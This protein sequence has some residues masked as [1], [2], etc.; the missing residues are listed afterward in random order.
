MIDWGLLQ[1]TNALGSYVS[2]FEAGRQRG[3]EKG[4]ESALSR[5]AADPQ[6]A[7]AELMKYDPQLGMTMQADAKRKA[8]E[9][10]RRG[11]GAQFA[12]DPRAAIGAATQAGDFDVAQAFSQMTKEQQ[13]KALE[14]QQTLAAIGGKLVKMP[15]DQRVAAMQQLGPAL[16]ARGF[17][18]E[19]I[20]GFDPTD[21]NLQALMT[22]LA[23]FEAKV[24]PQLFNT[25]DGIVSVAPGDDGSMS[26]DLVYDV[27]D[28]TDAPA[29]Y[30]W[31][32]GGDLAVIP[33]GPADPRVAGALAGSKR[34]S[35]RG[36]SG[37]A[38]AKPP[39][40][41]ILDP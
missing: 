11:Y 2:A 20:A 34:A 28:E 36:G 5:Y 35:S 4:V 6:G 30:R 32:D 31:T 8:D 14:H 37:G 38:V 12:A 21:E 39:S 7:A 23:E 41:F 16:V 13:A 29:G 15:Y 19:E 9:E 10:R 24:K 18:Q 33:G 1:P 17:G 3:K 27:G 40:G 22:S 26:G 25:R